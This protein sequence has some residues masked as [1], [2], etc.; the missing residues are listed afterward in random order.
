VVET[1][2]ANLGS[3]EVSQKAKLL[4]LGLEHDTAVLILNG[5]LEF[6][7]REA[8][9]DWAKVLNVGPKLLITS[10]SLKKLLS[11]VTRLWTE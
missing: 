6:K 10:N 2:K 3:K 1:F 11:N 8:K 7:M 5:Q 9:A 4:Q